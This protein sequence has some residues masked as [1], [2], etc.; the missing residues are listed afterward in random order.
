MAIFWIRSNRP[1]WSS[2]RDLGSGRWSSSIPFTAGA[3]GPSRVPWPPANTSTA[4]SPSA[5]SC[6]PA[7]HQLPLCPLSSDPLVQ[8]WKSSQF[9][10]GNEL[11]GMGSLSTLM[12]TVHKLNQDEFIIIGPGIEKLDIRWHQK[13][14]R[15]KSEHLLA[16]IVEGAHS[17]RN[18]L[19][20]NSEIDAWELL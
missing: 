9:A 4:T 1:A 14:Q 15:A 17:I 7:L 10:R 6:R 16:I 8:C 12:S 20:K 2:N 13:A 19:L 18:T 5:I 11:G 3:Q